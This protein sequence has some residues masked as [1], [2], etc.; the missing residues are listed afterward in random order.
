MTVQLRQ[1]IRSTALSMNSA[2][3]NQGTSGNV[4]ARYRHGF[5]VTPSGLN[6]VALD[7]GD[8]VFMSL[9]GEARG[10]RVP[11]SEWRFHRDI[12]AA[13]A[14]AG[15][16]VHCHSPYATAL[17]CLGRDIPAFHYMVAVAGGENIRCAGYA[18][19]GTQELSD[20]ALTALDGRK[21]CLLAN[22]G[23]IGIGGDLAEA[24]K[25]AIEVEALAAQYWRCLQ[26]GKPKLLSR[27]EMKRVLK[28]F[29]TYG[30]QPD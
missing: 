17:A 24:L 30:R 25:V 20:L 14:D 18:T 15:A 27:A 16:V 6:Y 8:I 28:K 11:S 13:R 4:S 21:A 7:P 2:G 10:K 23:M 29:A 5:L 19:F 12:Y 1:Q 26:V 22:H 9:D 3:I